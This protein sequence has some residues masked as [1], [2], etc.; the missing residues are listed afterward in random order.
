MKTIDPVV[1]L[2][3]FTE[4]LNPMTWVLLPAMLLI[5]LGFILVLIREKKLMARHMLLAQA[6]G[7]PG[8]VAALM[9]MAAVSSS[10]YSDAGGPIDWLL[11]ALI[12]TLKMIYATLTAYILSGWMPACRK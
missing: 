8:G 6:L 10:G 2:A 9:L 11:I 7:L 1:L 5:P 12:F 3:I 4:M